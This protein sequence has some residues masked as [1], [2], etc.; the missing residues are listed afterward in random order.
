LGNPGARGA[1]KIPEAGGLKDKKGLFRNVGREDSYLTQQN[2]SDGKIRSL[3][4]EAVDI[5]RRGKGGIISLEGHKRED[6]RHHMSNEVRCEGERRW[7]EGG[8]GLE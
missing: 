5:G 8:P 4:E 7:E 3:I 6:K 1:R 2:G